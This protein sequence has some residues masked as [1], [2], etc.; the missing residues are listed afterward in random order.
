MDTSF[1]V[2]AREELL[3][4]IQYLFFQPI[5]KCFASIWYE[6]QQLAIRQTRHQSPPSGV[7]RDI[8]LTRLDA[9]KNWTTTQI[10][11]EYS[12]V[13]Q[14][15]EGLFELLVNRIFTLC[16]RILVVAVDV[17]PDYLTISIPDNRRFVHAVYINAA[18]AFYRNPWLFLYS[19][20]G[21]VP[22]Y[23]QIIALEQTVNETVQRTIRELMNIDNI[24]HPLTGAP[25]VPVTAQ[26]A[27]IQFQPDP[28]DR[29]DEP[30][31]VMS[32]LL[33]NSTNDDAG[34]PIS[35]DDDDTN[36]NV[37][38]EVRKV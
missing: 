23:Q 11:E 3:S 29:E 27:Q 32:S 35:D 6:S 37:E 18:R 20:N 21:I 33:G 36:G 12:N 28:L 8:F 15:R 38:A 16:S 1:V 17:P 34:F 10:N 25:L 14:S 7:V 13:T 4:R 30:P 24:F 26:P 22:P 9:V 19:H 31:P 2:A 5:Y